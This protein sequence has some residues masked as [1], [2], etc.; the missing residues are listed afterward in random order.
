M[1][2]GVMQ[3]KFPPNVQW[4]ELPGAGG[5]GEHTFSFTVAH[6]AASVVLKTTSND[7]WSFDSVKLNGVKVSCGPAWLDNPKDGTYTS[8]PYAGTEVELP[9][10]C[11]TS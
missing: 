4:F 7:G 11:G 2:G 8:A 5:N 1:S 10:W 3:A 6:P 9:T